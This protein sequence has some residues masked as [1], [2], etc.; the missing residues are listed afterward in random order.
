MHNEKVSTLS[1]LVDRPATRREFLIKSSM[2][3]ALAPLALS[4]C[5]DETEHK[6]T[7]PPV[8]A[9]PSLSR[10]GRARPCAIPTAS[11]TPEGTP[12]STSRRPCPRKAK[13]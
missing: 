4:A 2:L 5:A 3:G 8:R 6:T 11:S 7:R 10:Q 12:T 1:E 13:K 9:F